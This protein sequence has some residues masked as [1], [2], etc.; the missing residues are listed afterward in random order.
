MH[1][2]VTNLFTVHSG[3]SKLDVADDSIAWTTMKFEFQFK[4]SKFPIKTHTTMCPMDSVHGSYLMGLTCSDS[5]LES[6]I[7]K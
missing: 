5:A 4:N 1:F 2:F 6:R 3:Q 7:H